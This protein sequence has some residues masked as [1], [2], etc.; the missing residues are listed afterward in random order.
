MNE[1]GGFIRYGRSTRCFRGP[2]RDRRLWT[3]FVARF[4]PSHLS[5]PQIFDALHFRQRFKRLRFSIVELRQPPPATHRIRIHQNRTHFLDRSIDR[6]INRDLSITHTR[7]RREWKRL[8]WW[9]A[10]P[11]G[12]LNRREV[13]SKKMNRLMK[14]MKAT[15]AVDWTPLM[16]FPRMKLKIRVLNWEKGGFGEDEVFCW[17]WMMECVCLYI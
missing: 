8:T 9:G 2:L 16:W 17:V 14:E 4:D 10:A 5:L 6:S 1:Q 7:S 13:R 15:A 11:W 3:E 12:L